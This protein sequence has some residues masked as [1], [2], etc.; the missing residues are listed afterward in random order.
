MK[1]SENIFTKITIVS[2]SVLYLFI[3]LTYVLF[4]PNYNNQRLNAKQGLHN[5]T[6]L[7]P[8][9]KN[10]GYN[11]GKAPI[12]EKVFKTTIQHKKEIF[13]ALLEATAIITSVVIVTN[14]LVSRRLQSVYADSYRYT[15]LQVC[16]LRI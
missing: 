13:I 16:A 4:L 14:S 3:A 2:L 6:V 10:I 15:Y 7:S 5:H 12:I 1:T 11:A 9:K 8:S